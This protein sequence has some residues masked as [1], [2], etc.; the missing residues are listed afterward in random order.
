M[1][2]AA[3][4][5]AQL[6][7]SFRALLREALCLEL[8]IDHCLQLPRTEIRQQ[9]IP[10]RSARVGGQRG[11]DAFRRC[12]HQAGHIPCCRAAAGIFKVG[13]Q[14]TFFGF[15]QVFAVSIAMDRLNRA[16]SVA[17][18]L[19]EMLMGLPQLDQLTAGKCTPSLEKLEPTCDLV[20][21]FK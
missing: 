13:P 5:V 12:A 15:K 18:C 7:V 4:P 1:R 19:G 11:L 6:R 9:L 17:E 16:V 21:D 14:P 2:L 3:L 20:K 10:R 8:P